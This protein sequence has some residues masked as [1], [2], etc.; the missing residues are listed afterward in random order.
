MQIAKEKSLLEELKADVENILKAIEDS[1]ELRNFLN[2]PL[3]KM[4]K[5]RSI[6]EQIFKSKV[7]DLSLKFIVQIADQKREALLE[8]IC[9]EFI[10]QY[11][12]EHNIAKVHLSTATKLTDAQRQGVLDFINHNY[13][14]KSIELEAK[15]DEDLIGGLVLRIEDNQIDG[16][17]K[18]KLQDIKQEL[19]HA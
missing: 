2:S 1:D 19:I 6:L 16:S 12:I 8:A 17:I 13:N 10:R 7:N 4:D 5:K 3:I 18:R 14:F 9:L 15:V 11:N